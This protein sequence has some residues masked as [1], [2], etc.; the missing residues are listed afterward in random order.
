MFIG[1]NCFVVDELKMLS[2]RKPTNSTR[3]RTLPDPFRE[4]H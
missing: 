2:V 4:E 1:L 3:A